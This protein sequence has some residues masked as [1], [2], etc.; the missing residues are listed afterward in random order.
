M[1]ELEDGFIAHR[2]DQ[3]LFSMLCKR[4]GLPGYRLPTQYGLL[5]PERAVPGP[6]GQILKA[7]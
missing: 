2:H 3:S 1:D 4:H 5:G 6:Y 7:K